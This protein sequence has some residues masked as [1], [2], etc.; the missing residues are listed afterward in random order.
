MT[1]YH[2]PDETERLQKLQDYRKLFADTQVTTTHLLKKSVMIPLKR[3]EIGRTVEQQNVNHP[4]MR[5][6]MEF[7]DFN[8]NHYN[9]V[10]LVPDPLDTTLAKTHALATQNN[11]PLTVRSLSRIENDYTHELISLP[12][13]PN[14]IEERKAEEEAKLRE[15]LRRQQEDALIQKQKSLLTATSDGLLE[16]S[17]DKQ[18]KEESDG[19][20]D[21]YIYRTYFREEEL[22]RV[23]ECQSRQHFDD[24]LVWKQEAA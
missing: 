2:I 4:F 7:D 23:K 8:Y 11:A 13:S 16:N 20:I 15:A 3:D 18:K 9:S 1:P 10:I 5:G 22:K 17:T 21:E 14:Q 12:L 24:L 19:E 6:V